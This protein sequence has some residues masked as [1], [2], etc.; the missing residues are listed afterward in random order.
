MVK[1]LYFG[2]SNIGMFKLSK[3]KEIRVFK[4]KGATARGLSKIDNANRI[5]IINNIDR[6]RPECV[7]F[8]FGVVDIFFTVYYKLFESEKFEFDG[9]KFVKTIVD[10]YVNFL[11]EL[12][13]KH[14]NT[15][16]YII[17]P[18][19]SP[20]TVDNVPGCIIHY[21]IVPEKD[22]M[23]KINKLKPYIQRKYRN[24]L[25]D[26]FIKS[27]KYNLRGMN[28]F[29]V[30]N[31][32]PKISSNGI[33]RDKYIISHD[34]SLYNIHLCWETTILHYLKILDK[35]GLNINT[36]DLSQFDEYMKRKREI[37]KKRDGNKKK[38]LTIIFER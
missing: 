7:V 21:G 8:C 34:V 5:D 1:Y 23:E 32:M 17:P 29:H 38:S 16:F 2:D 26:L 15:Q 25:V 18:H 4:Y 20:V 10:G 12:A 37:A 6:N 14:S 3:N 13:K 24:S 11:K 36:I 31:I 9:K 19:Y 28:N 30:I 35:C 27:L 33:I 22:V